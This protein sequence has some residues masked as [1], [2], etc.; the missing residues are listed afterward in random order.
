MEIGDRT[1]LDDAID[2]G[3][4]VVDREHV[5][6]SHP[7]LATTAKQR[8]TARERRELHVELARVAGGDELRAVHLALAT[9][10]PDEELAATVAATAAAAAARGA[11]REA[12]VLAE[13][14]L[15]LTPED[16][17]ERSG[18]VLALAE[19]LL[20]AGEKQRLTDLLAP[21]LD[22]LPRETLEYE[23]VCS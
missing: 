8:A 12:V 6:A 5:R 10:L 2:A 16:S 21:E 20:V 14:A 13:H 18:R 11:A 15:R 9:D 17:D 19:Y 1:A 3:L 7:L 22:S 4:L 23:P